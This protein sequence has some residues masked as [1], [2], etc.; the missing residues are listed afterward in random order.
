MAS[1]W[2]NKFFN[3]SKEEDKKCSICLEQIEN[4]SDCK[5]TE[6]CGTI[7]H[8]K[9]L[10][11]TFISVYTKNC[12]MCRTKISFN[13]LTDIIE[14]QNETFF[15]ETE[16]QWKNIINNFDDLLKKQ[17]YYTITCGL[18]DYIE[19]NERENYSEYTISD[20]ERESNDNERDND[21]E[22]NDN[23]SNDNDSND[24][25]NCKCDEHNCITPD[26]K[27]FIDIL[28]DT[29]SNNYIGYLYILK[30]A[31]Q[32]NDLRAFNKINC[33]NFNSN[34]NSV[35]LLNFLIITN[36]TN[37]F[38]QVIQIYAPDIE[39]SVIQQTFNECLEK[40]QYTNANSILK[41]YQILLPK[42]K[43]T[44]KEI[45]ELSPILNEYYNLVDGVYEPKN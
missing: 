31:I 1:N 39:L 12:P 21:S 35:K 16:T 10:A 22:Y 20:S 2:Q 25:N 45:T 6:C 34:E 40:E 13:N 11:M 38:E 5:I 37:I 32:R 8:S 27:D 14:K 23:E 41:H 42:E 33:F 43:L 17:H 3:L 30:M 9:C 28:D 4:F 36:A 29:C 19:E 24:S 18:D 44:T 26:V 7:F 15:K